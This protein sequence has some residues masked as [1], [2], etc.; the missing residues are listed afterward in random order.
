MVPTSIQTA[1][2]QVP[3]AGGSFKVWRGPV[4]KGTGLPGLGLCSP[5]VAEL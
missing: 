5:T 3:L 2:Q 1:G 4:Y